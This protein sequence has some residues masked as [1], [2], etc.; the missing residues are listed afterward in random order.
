[1]NNLK[2]YSFHKSSE[3][4]DILWGVDNVRKP[5]HPKPAPEPAPEARGARTK[6]GAGA[7]AP[8]GRGVSD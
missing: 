3:S 2:H 6:R 4:I 8:E 5:P 7:A 1:M